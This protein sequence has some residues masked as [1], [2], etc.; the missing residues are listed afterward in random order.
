MIVKITFLFSLI[1]HGKL[2]L[3]RVSVEL[4]CK[5]V[6]DNIEFTIL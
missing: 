1:C 2:G 4:D 6:V 3:S 5:L